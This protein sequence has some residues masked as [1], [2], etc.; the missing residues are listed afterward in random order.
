M[1]FS[2]LIEFV[3][4]ISKCES[5]IFRYFIFMESN[6][7]MLNDH[8]K[9]NKYV[10]KNH[11]SGKLTF[12]CPNLLINH[13]IISNVTASFL[14]ILNCQRFCYTFNANCMKGLSVEESNPIT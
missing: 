5:F 10:N 13:L 2:A 6:L 1:P 14:V 12:L 3:T 4:R 8:G 11:R 9:P 7:P